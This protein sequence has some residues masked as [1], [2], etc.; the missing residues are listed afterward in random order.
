MY[1]R[2][3]VPI[4]IVIVLAAVIF[5]GYLVYQ[6]QLP[7]RFITSPPPSPIIN[8]SKEP[9]VSE[10]IKNTYSPIWKELFMEKNSI[11]EEYFSKHIK[12]INIYKAELNSGESLNIRYQFVIDWATTLQIIDS[13][14]IKSKDL[15]RY[16]SPEEVKQN[17]K[18]Q[19]GV[20]TSPHK[21]S[22]IIPVESIISYDTAIN[23]LKTKCSSLL[24]TEPNN[25]AIDD[26]INSD[27]Y[28]EIYLKAGGVIDEKKNK[29][30]SGRI[31][32]YD[33]EVTDCSDTFCWIN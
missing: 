6:K 8:T 14:L 28:G 20:G 12:I 5:G 30:K 10:D 31:G 1:Q 33:G 25:I 13:L 11:S 16:Y 23:N 19:N 4:F 3:L 29:C 7:S 15:S 17:A 32:L 9:P 22:R 2:G 27:Q 26:S 21:I 24:K 18:T